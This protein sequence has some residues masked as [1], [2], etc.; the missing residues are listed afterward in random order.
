M[1]SNTLLEV[2]LS[3]SCWQSKADSLRTEGDYN[4]IL[5]QLRLCALCKWSAK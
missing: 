2:L 3:V 1:L 5:R 4:A